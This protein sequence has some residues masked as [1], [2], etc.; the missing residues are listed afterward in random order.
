M[1]GTRRQKDHIN[2]DHFDEEFEQNDKY[3]P[4]DKVL[5][6]IGIARK[7]CRTMTRITTARTENTRKGGCKFKWWGRNK[8]R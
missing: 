7:G 6:V 3:D 5:L 1:R 4:E 2:D 8:Q